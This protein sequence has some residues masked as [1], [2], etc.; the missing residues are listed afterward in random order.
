MN[1]TH[2]TSIVYCREEET[3]NKYYIA[4]ILWNFK[5]F[6]L[7]LS[8]GNCFRSA[9]SSNKIPVNEVWCLNRSLVK[10]DVFMVAA[11]SIGI[12]LFNR[13]TLFAVK[14]SIVNRNG[15]AFQC[16]FVVEFLVTVAAGERS[17][18]MYEQ[19]ATQTRRMAKWLQNR[20]E[21]LWNPQNYKQFLDAK[22]NYLP[23]SR[24]DSRASRSLDSLYDSD[25]YA[26]VVRPSK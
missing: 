10:L 8:N 26:A 2:A 9:D 21:I 1:F 3:A 4:R 11:I 6:P 16:T 13:C 18:S 22:T 25:W 23:W 15:V 7:I 17:A 14:R 5:D 20:M 24:M 19:M 12:L